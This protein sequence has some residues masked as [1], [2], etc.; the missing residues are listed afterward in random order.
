MLEILEKIIKEILI[1]NEKSVN[2]YKSGEQKAFNFLIGQ[3]MQKTNKRADY[4]TIKKILE[5]KLK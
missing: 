4:N 1:D 5:E 3:V 2:D